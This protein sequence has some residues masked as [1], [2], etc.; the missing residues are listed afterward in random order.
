MKTIFRLAASCAM[1]A[2]LLSPAAAAQYGS[3]DVGNACKTSGGN[4]GT[5]VRD[6]TMGSE[7]FVCKKGGKACE[8]AKTIAPVKPQVN[9]TEVGTG[10]LQSTPKTA[11]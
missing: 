7:T 1:T 3:G 9:E 5:V 11:K 2:M 10:I 8:M 6:N 4:C